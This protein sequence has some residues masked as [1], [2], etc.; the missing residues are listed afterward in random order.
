MNKFATLLMFFLGASFRLLTIQAQSC[1]VGYYDV[2]PPPECEFYID[3]NGEEQEECTAI[4]SAAFAQL[5]DSNTPTLTEPSFPL[6]EMDIS[7]DCDCTLRVYSGQNLSGCYVQEDII[8]DASEHIEV[9]G[10]IWTR[11]ANP[12]SFELTCTF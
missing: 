2:A 11:S 8:T 12:Q 3:E 6:S 10:G 5:L 7:G 1:E 9:I 4:G